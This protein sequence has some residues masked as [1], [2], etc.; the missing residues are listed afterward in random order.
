MLEAYITFVGIGW[1]LYDDSFYQKL[2]VFPNLHW[3][4]KDVSQ[5]LNLKLFHWTPV[6]ASKPQVVSANSLLCFAFTKK[7]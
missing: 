6:V 1:F 4:A 2:S 3:D 5:W 7:A